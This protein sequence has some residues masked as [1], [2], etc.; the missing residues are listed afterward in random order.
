MAQVIEVKS[1]MEADEMVKEMSAKR[2]AVKAFGAAK[3]A[4][5]KATELQADYD[6]IDSTKENH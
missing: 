4:A 2:A 5:L 1:E 3:A 6:A